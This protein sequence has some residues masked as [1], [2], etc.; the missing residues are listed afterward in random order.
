MSAERQGLELTRRT[1][2]ETNVK[3]PSFLMSKPTCIQ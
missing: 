2:A 3:L 1:K